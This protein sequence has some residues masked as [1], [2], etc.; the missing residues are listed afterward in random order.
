[1]STSATPSFLLSLDNPDCCRV[2]GGAVTQLELTGCR[3]APEVGNIIKVEW[4]F[5]GAVAQS[6]LVEVAGVELVSPAVRGAYVVVL[7]WAESSH[8]GVPARP[9]LAT[10]PAPPQLPDSA[11]A[12][13][14]CYRQELQEKKAVK[15]R[16]SIAA[17]WR[18]AELLQRTHQTAGS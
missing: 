6:F 1:M 15:F 14:D 4:L 8:D 5:L 3:R 16:S 10:P 18:K 11:S 9:Q 7:R 2:F 13:I 12:V 17:A